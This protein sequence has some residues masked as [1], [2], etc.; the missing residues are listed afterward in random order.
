MPDV[1]ESINFCFQYKHHTRIYRNKCEEIW[2]E[3]RTFN[4][5]IRAHLLVI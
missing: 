4:G 2:N 3:P 1:L 5:S